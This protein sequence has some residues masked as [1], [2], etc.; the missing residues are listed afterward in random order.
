[1]APKVVRNSGQLVVAPAGVWWEIA[2]K[3]DTHAVL[4]AIENYAAAV[5]QPTA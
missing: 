4:R 3:H 5:L 1:M 2:D